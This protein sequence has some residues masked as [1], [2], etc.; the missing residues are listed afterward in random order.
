MFYDY[1]IYILIEYLYILYV[2]IYF[3]GI[4]EFNYIKLFLL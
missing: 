1:N 4:D 2:K 3:K